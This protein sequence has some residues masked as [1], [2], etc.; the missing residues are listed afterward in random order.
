MNKKD[1]NKKEKRRGTKKDRNKKGRLREI[2]GKAITGGIRGG[3][4]K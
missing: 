4:G 1:R 2:Y 3:Y